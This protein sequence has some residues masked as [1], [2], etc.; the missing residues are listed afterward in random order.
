MASVVHTLWE[1]GDQSPLILP[2]TLPLEAPEVIRELVRHLSDNWTPIIE[3]DVDGPRSLPIEIDLSVPNLGRYHATRRV[4]RTIF[5]GSAPKVGAAQ[6]GL[7]EKRVKLGA[8][9]PGEPPAVFGDALR[10]LADRATYLYRD[11]D[12]YWYDVQPTV[13]KLAED[14][15]EQ[16]KGKRELVLQE[17]EAR[18]GK[19]LR[20]GTGLMR[21]H[22]FPKS[23]ADIPDEPE[24]RLV[25]FSPEA[26]YQKSDPE[27]PALR[28]AEAILK[29]RGNAPRQYQ[30]ALV[31]LAADQN[32]L[33][34][35]EDTVRR[36]LAW[37]GI[38]DERE[39][40]NLTPF[41]VRQAESQLREAEEELGARIPETYIWLIVPVQD[42]PEDPVQM[43]TYR[44][45]GNRGLVER[46]VQKLV[47][48]GL[49]AR[50]LAPGILRKYLDDVPLWDDH[51]GRRDAAVGRLVD[52]FFGYLYLPRLA[53]PKV[54]LESVSRGVGLLTWE[55]DGF[56]WAE[57]FDETAQRYVGLV[58]GQALTLREANGLVV[59]PDTARRQFEREL[60][61]APTETITASTQE[62][63]IASPATVGETKATRDPGPEPPRRFYGRLEVEPVD[64]VK[65]ASRLAEELVAHLAKL[66]GAKVRV[67]IEVDAEVPGGVPDDVAC[68]V[69][70][71]ARVLN[72]RWEFE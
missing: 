2:A 43:E 1:G 48:E 60:K 20:A 17:I 45:N 71:N 19:A 34:D 66:P 3:K 41:Q 64:L 56:A 35:L 63:V 55:R 26:P 36:Y 44:L 37:K 13:T 6:R 32:R 67:R 40:L 5:L 47:R 9:M 18:V 31:F 11:Q 57:R 70:E 39:Q 25:V 46:A 21:V 7:E 14:R 42:R 28:E 69:Q 53:T 54:L 15:A 52:Y 65:E 50:E 59:H 72:V 12:R 27:S 38:L 24:A 29:L 49:L 51:E 10:R 68:V 58:V 4:A 30:N 22:A 61:E 16:L 62:S 8:I 33:E 23:A